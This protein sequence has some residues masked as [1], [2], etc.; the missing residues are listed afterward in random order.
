M[1]G[2]TRLTRHRAVVLAVVTVLL[3]AAGEGIAAAA[4]PAG[5]GGGGILGPLNV[6]SSEGVPIDRYE[7]DPMEQA[8]EAQGG[9]D[10]QDPGSVQ[11][12]MD[13]VGATV[14]GFLASGL[15]ALSRTATG[16]ACW[17]I[18]QVY[19]FPIIEKL[20][21]PAQHI[22]DAYER[23]IIGPLGL[24]GIALAWAFVFGLVM[25]MRG[26]VARGAGELVLSLLISA[27]TATTLVQPAV[28]LG[29]DG[30]VQQTQR[31]ALQAATITTNAGNAGPHVVTGPCALLHGS[32][33]DICL[34]QEQARASTAAEQDRIK[35]C[36]PLTGAA[37]QV[38]LSG[39]KPLNAADVSVPITRTLTD[40]LVVQPYMLLQYGR[41][42]EKDDPLY[43]AHTQ[44]IA[45]K[46]TPDT[47]ACRD[48][49]GPGK[50]MC[51][52]TAAQLNPGLSELDKAG[53][54]GKAVI[55]RMMKPDW[56][57]V[58]GALLVLI[59]ALI[60]VLVVVAMALALIAAQFGCVIAAIGA[61]VVFPVA[62]L[63]GPGRGLLWKW[64]GYLAG[65]MLILVVTAVFIPLFGIAAQ[66]VLADSTSTLLERLLILDGLVLTALVMY[67]RIIRGSR[68]VGTRLARRMSYAKIGGSHLM[69]GAAAD[70][71]A[72]FS[73]LGM[74]GV[75]GSSAHAALLTRSGFATEALDAARG[76]LVPFRFG[77][78][79]AHVALIGPKRP[80][81]K[82]AAVGPDGRP[83]PP[84]E[85]TPGSAGAIAT[86]APEGSASG[87]VTV[88]RAPHGRPIRGRHTPT[89]P[90]HAPTGPRPG[91]EQREEGVVPAGARLE[92]ALRTTR[93][94][95]ALVA[96][97]KV[98][99]HSTLGLP[100]T[101]NRATRVGST[102]A[103]ALGA[104]LGRQ[105]D[106]HRGARQRWIAD[107]RAGLGFGR[108][109]EEAPAD[110]SSAGGPVGPQP[111]APPAPPEGAL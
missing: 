21:G 71:A 25:I 93:G 85:P 80:A 28:L 29:Y 100:A 48:L 3:W 53:A 76:S 8:Q 46:K 1:S 109:P 86:T 52:K 108:T 78:K 60:I 38:C 57:K 110:G 101:W 111:P 96:T 51:E 47:S 74:G 98:A 99:Y 72:A 91:R 24:A 87:R 44:L 10:D 23:D 33:R 30:P 54:E 88:P 19:R 36:Q 94:G 27:L 37:R 7:L 103:S 77:L 75:A 32:P 45:T 34:R 35:R 92:A 43:K 90:A 42:L 11:G 69:G 39:E 17:L 82:P 83:L 79:A 50:E 61:V 67:K 102:R 95:R 55:E 64:L 66:A 31:A 26:R 13:S 73:A 105:R 104:E 18:D 89:H 41:V 63:P 14:R 16:F 81:I 15:F 107:S 106:H 56:D 6:T 9:P 59:A 20:T 2:F 58:L 84:T 62:I 49:T 5:G 12:G 68:A 4:D 70:T 40:S 97:S 22:S 65:C